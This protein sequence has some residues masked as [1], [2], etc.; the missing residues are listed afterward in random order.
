M[1]TAI[2]TNNQLSFPS[3]YKQSEIHSMHNHS[4]SSITNSFSLSGFSLANE[5]E[6]SSL[7]KAK[8][9]NKEPMQSQDFQINNASNH[10]GES[11]QMNNKLT[12]ENNE[13][14]STTDLDNNQ[15]PQK[16]TEN[17]LDDTTKSD[18]IENVKTIKRIKPLFE[19]IRDSNQ[20]SSQIS[21]VEDKISRN[22]LNNSDSSHENINSSLFKRKKY[23]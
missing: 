9:R 7:D 4:K 10:K 2:A 19:T 3:M 21:L 17:N 13:S 5:N 18:S 22:N 1:S 6:R 20:S 16:N 12:P 8:K 15:Q 11:Y 14:C 23:L